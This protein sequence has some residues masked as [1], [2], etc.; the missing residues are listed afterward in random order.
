MREKSG[1]L[2]MGEYVRVPIDPDGVI[3]LKP[4]IDF[5]DPQEIAQETC[6]WLHDEAHKRA[7][8]G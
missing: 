4:G 5:R 2:P 3:V 6:D 1:Y 7:E 8:N